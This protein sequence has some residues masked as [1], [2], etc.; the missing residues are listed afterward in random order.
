MSDTT[1]K[2]TNLPDSITLALVGYTNAVMV[3]CSSRSHEALGL[4]KVA[5]VAARAELEQAIGLELAK[6]TGG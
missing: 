4:T 1:A 6:T 5:M 2:V 3:H